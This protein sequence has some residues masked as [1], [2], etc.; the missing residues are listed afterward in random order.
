MAPLPLGVLR[1]LV[2][3]LL[4]IDAIADRKLE[5]GMPLVILGIRVM[6][7]VGGIMM[8]P[9]QAKIDKWCRLIREALSRGACRCFGFCCSLLRMCDR[10]Q[11]ECVPGKPRRWQGDS[12]G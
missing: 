6:F 5:A 12:R 7:S 8:T 2:R 1:R 4:G 3:C 9:D 10:Y 11:G